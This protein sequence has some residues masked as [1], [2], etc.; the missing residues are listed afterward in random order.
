MIWQEV[1][2]FLPYL[3]VKPKEWP[4]EWPLLRISNSQGTTG[5]FLP[6][7]GA[8]HFVLKLSVGCSI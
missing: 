6:S 5:I 4:N 1:V 3:Y 8:I 2:S 7:R